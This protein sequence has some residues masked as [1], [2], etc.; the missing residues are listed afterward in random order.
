MSNSLNIDNNSDLGKS[1]IDPLAILSE[2][3]KFKNEST[4]SGTN[5]LNSVKALKASV[6][7]TG[8]ASTAGLTKSDLQKLRHRLGAYGPIDQIK[9]S[10]SANADT[11]YHS[12]KNNTDVETNETKP[13][14]VN[15]RT[16]KFGKKSISLTDEQY[17]IVTAERD[18]HYKIIACAG[19]GKTT[20][21]L[22]RIKYL[23]DSGVKPWQIMLTTF[24]VDAAENMKMRM[25]DLFGFKINIY[26][27]TIDALAYRFYNA[28]FKRPDFV[29][30]SEY[31]SEFLKFLKEDNEK[32]K[33]LRARF[34]YVFFDEFQD[35]NDV[36]FD[37]IREFA[38]TARVTVIGD[39]A[40]NVYQ[41]R[42]SNMDFILNF[43][44]YINSIQNHKIVVSSENEL[45]GTPVAIGCVVK[46]LKK[47]FRSTP[48]I[49]NLANASIKNNT[50]QIPKEMLSTNKSYDRLP[51]VNKYL[52]EEEQAQYTLAY[53]IRYIKNKIPQD[54][55]A[56]LSRNNYSI[57]YVE[58]AIE[59]HNIKVKNTAVKGNNGIDVDDDKDNNID[60]VVNYVSL[61]NDDTKDT[62][63]KIM[64]DHITLTT[65]HKAKGLEWDVVFVLSCNDDKFPSETTPVKIQEDRRLFY[66]ASTRAK[67]YLNF[68]F[69]SNSISRFIGEL[70][71]SLYVFEKYHPKYFVYRDDRNIKFKNGVTQLIEM[72]EP[73]DI[74]FL[75]DTGILPPIIP[76]TRRV[77]APHKYSNYIDQYYLQSD[78]GTYIDRYISRQ[79][80]IKCPGSGGL[81]DS[82]ANRVLNTVCLPKPLHD[83]YVKYNYNIQ[84]KLD[85]MFDK[86]INIERNNSNSWDDNHTGDNHVSPDNMQKDS[87]VN[88]HVNIEDLVK[89]LD[90]SAD[91]PHYIQSIERENIPALEELV[92]TLIRRSIEI[93][94]YPS[95]LH[96]A[97]SN[98][99]PYEFREKF[100]TSYKNYRK[101]D[102]KRPQIDVRKDV[103]NVS[104]CQNVYDGRRRLLYKDCFDEFDTDKGLYNDID[105]W[106]HS[107]RHRRI[108]TKMCLVHKGYGICG[109]L[110]MI[111]LTKDGETIIDVKCSLNSEYKLEWIIQLMM[112]SA[113]YK[114]NFRKVINKL[115]VYNPLRGTYTEVDL[116][117][118]NHHLDLL[119]FMDNVRTLRMK[120]QK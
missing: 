86:L 48:E 46:T 66:V 29:G 13:D 19:S 114:H 75:R 31:C 87:N 111:D 51:R 32:T 61:I 88:E 71:R 1:K 97:P 81:V 96:V 35:C 26:V 83:M 67:R 58:E 20:T 57:K 47:N 79:L 72:L 65:V 115:G 2:R 93:G 6:K 4:S 10:T 120:N 101:F 90:R 45:K 69:T 53:I 99:M 11:T 103:Y 17:E 70:D 52:N 82:V 8:I 16:I 5:T 42:G 107:Y 78:Y 80:G 54:Q 21:I 7:K 76:H 68:S 64:K 22:C 14:Q 33:K 94:V 27:G 34:E 117:N 100:E 89:N 28:Y 25:H 12:D 118:W 104:L 9:G 44:N 91:D 109:E 73:R 15:D 49:I 102:P 55:I 119:I 106:A 24:N 74:Q 40:Q 41:W 105:A 98:Y 36:Q 38:K 108:Y 112:Y 50:D 84:R 18:K 77:H 85:L 59:K 116:E 62:K 95:Q 60:P 3:L 56:V 113:L 39:D 63:P 37:I 110:D 92:D 43:E 30:V 23:I